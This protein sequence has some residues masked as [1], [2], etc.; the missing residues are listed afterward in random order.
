MNMEADKIALA[1]KILDTTNPEIIQ[2][3]KD[4]F[5]DRTERDFW[6]DLSSQQQEEIKR[7]SLEVK[8]EKFVDYKTFIAKHL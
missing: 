3:I 1:K 2:A 4:V 6:D 7:A 5:K 8:E